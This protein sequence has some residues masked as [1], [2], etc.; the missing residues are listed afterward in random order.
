MRK[1][2]DIFQLMPF[3]MGN[4]NK[5]HRK[6]FSVCQGISNVRFWHKADVENF[7]MMA[8]ITELLSPLGAF[9][10]ATVLTAQ[11]NQPDQVGIFES[12][13]IMQAETS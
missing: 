12:S 13:R 3:Y 6:L 7:F 9:E 5:L 8:T 2:S 10:S 4:R 11:C 1:L